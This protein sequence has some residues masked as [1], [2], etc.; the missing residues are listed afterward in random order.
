MDPLVA[1]TIEPYE[2]AGDNP[3]NWGD[4]LGLKPKLPTSASFPF[5]GTT[6]TVSETAEVDSGHCG[7]DVGVSS[8]GTVDAA[9]GHSTVEV[10]SD[11]AVNGLFS[12]RGVTVS[13]DGSVSFTST[14][15]RKVGNDTVA[16]NI[17]ASMSASDPNSPDGSNAGEYAVGGAAGI[18]VTVWWLG[19][20]ASPL[21]GFLFPVCA[22]AG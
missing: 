15:S 1:E 21:C 13:S 2:Y 17:T 4:P 14:T 20:F 22:V 19:K 7:L 11:G 12:N 8:N 10:S 3:V 18:G 9:S 6:V 5:F 16:I